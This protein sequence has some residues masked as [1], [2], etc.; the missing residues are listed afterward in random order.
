M[1][2]CSPAE[3]FGVDSKVKVLVDNSPRLPEG[4]EAETDDYVVVTTSWGMTLKRWKHKAST[5]QVLDVRIKTPD[6]WRKVKERMTPSDDRIPWG[7]LRENWSQWR[8]QG[9]LIEGTGWFGFDI[10]HSHFIGTERLL[11][12]FI[13]YPEWVRDMF[14]TELELC[15]NLFDRVWEEGYRFDALRWPDDMGYKYNQF[16]S[17]DMYRDLLK[18]IHHQAIDWAHAKGIPAVLH[19][20][21]D[22]RPF[23]PELVA[24]GLDGLNPLEVKAG[25]DPIQVKKEYGDRLLLHGG[26]NAL[27]WNNVDEMEA[28]VRAKLPA[29]KES[30]GYIWATDHSVPD[31]VSL[32]DFQHIVGVVKEVGAY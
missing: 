24:L 15:L 11:M 12:A 9:V 21:G 3:F 32:K 25:V 20:C 31:N 8:Q 4:L 29:L 7:K 17:L 23:I 13:D 6:D 27:L 1:G 14:Q 19:S 22:I 10:T 16:F 30:G 28:E 18:P 26:F 2:D 5:P